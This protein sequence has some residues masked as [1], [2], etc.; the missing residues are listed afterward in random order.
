MPDVKTMSAQDK[1]GEAMRR[2]IPMLPAEAQEQVKAVLTPTALA[3]AAGT[4]IVWAGSQFFGV[5]E[6][7]DV[8]LLVVGVATIG[9][10]VFG[11]G[12]NFMI[13]PRPL[14]TLKPTQI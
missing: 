10:G 3:I 7:V 4:L 11:G 12:V 8:I 5:G 6:V 9:L 2:S 1:I 14:L 13:L